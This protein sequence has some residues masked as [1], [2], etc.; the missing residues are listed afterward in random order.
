MLITAGVFSGTAGAAPSEG[1][2]HFKWALVE[3]ACTK[4]LL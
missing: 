4:F 3:G 2:S 1:I